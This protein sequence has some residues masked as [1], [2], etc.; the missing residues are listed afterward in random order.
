MVLQLLSGAAK[1]FRPLVL[2]PPQEL[3]DQYRGKNHGANPPHPYAIADVCYRNLLHSVGGEKRSQSLIISGE[4]G[5]GKTE[6]AK[7][8]KSFSGLLL[9]QHCGTRTP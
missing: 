6:T 1:F 7:V 2:S 3:K 4:S 8:G 9:W 5:A